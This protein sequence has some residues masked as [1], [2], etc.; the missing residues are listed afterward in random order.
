MKLRVFSLIMAFFILTASFFTGT[1]IESFIPK[2]S[3]INPDT[4][5]YTRSVNC[6]GEIVEQNREDVYLSLPIIASEVRFSVGDYVNQGDVIAVIDKAATAT[7]LISAYTSGVNDMVYDA[8][9]N[10]P[11]DELSDALA[12]FGNSVSLSDNLKNIPNYIRAGISGTLTSLNISCNK[13]TTAYTSIATIVDDSTLVAKVSVNEEN[14]DSIVV[15][16]SAVL[17]GSA[18]SDEKYDAYVSKIYPSAYKKYNSLVS[19]TVVDVI[20]TPAS[21]DHKLKSGYTTKANII[22]EQVDYAIT[23][24]YEAVMQDENNKEYVYVLENSRAVKRYITTGLEL[25]KGFEIL[26][27]IDITE[28]VIKNPVGIAENSYVKV[29]EYEN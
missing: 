9:L 25:S 29:V 26:D 21:S 13:P 22:I 4:T 20:V 18:F 10:L 17:T 12:V 8:I 23:I 15:G 14:I 2:V 3:V 7:A 28:L 11:K 27:G 24:P 5:G 19:E 1:I 6:A 16:A